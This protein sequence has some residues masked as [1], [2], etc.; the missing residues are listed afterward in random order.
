MAEILDERA[1]P[2]IECLFCKKPMHRFLLGERKFAVWTHVGQDALDCKMVKFNVDFISKMAENLH[3]WK[4]DFDKFHS[5]KK[6]RLE[7]CHNPR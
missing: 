1:P 7:S 5:V 2:I 6:H 3:I 4:K